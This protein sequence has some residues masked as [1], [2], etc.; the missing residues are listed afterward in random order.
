MRIDRRTY[1]ARGPRSRR[2]SLRRAKDELSVPGP[3]L[4]VSQPDVPAPPLAALF[5]G[6]VVAMQRAEPPPEP[7]DEDQTK[8]GYCGGASCAR[9]EQVRA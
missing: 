1:H 4:P 6:L 5:R 2:A 9:C 8:C 3:P 7:E